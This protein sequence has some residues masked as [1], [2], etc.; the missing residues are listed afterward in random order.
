MDPNAN[1]AEQRT[2]VARILETFEYTGKVNAEDAARL[3][4]LVQALDDWIMHEGFLPDAWQQPT[5]RNR[6][7]RGRS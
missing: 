1:L 5:T 7:V 6:W 3:A 4:E 2:L